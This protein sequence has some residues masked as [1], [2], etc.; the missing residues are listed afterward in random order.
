MGELDPAALTAAREAKGWRQLDLARETGLSA[1]Y[2]NQLER[3]HRQPSALVV[4]TL[5]RVLDVSIDDLAGRRVECPVCGSI[6]S[7]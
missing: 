4:S 1:P 7:A 6:F 5:A 3:G 2:V